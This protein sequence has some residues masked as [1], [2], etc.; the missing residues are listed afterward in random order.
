MFEYVVHKLREVDAP[1]PILCHLAVGGARENALQEY[2]EWL[3]PWV[4]SV[5]KRLKM[6]LKGGSPWH[7]WVPF[8]AK[9]AAL[10]RAAPA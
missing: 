1:L 2:L 8:R 7:I 4:R 10:V 9:Y 5:K 3:F 6:A